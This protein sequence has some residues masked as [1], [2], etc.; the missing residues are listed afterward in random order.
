MNVVEN[1]MVYI[2]QYPWK[3]A[4]YTT[5]LECR[6]YSD[7]Q[8]IVL[9]LGFETMDFF[10]FNREKRRMSKQKTC[11]KKPC[12]QQIKTCGSVQTECIRR[13]HGHAFMRLTTDVYQAVFEI[14]TA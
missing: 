12:L 8:V 6:S 3:Q 13:S 4:L 11:G 5:N 7:F 1:P 2:A 10:L 14:R 9:S